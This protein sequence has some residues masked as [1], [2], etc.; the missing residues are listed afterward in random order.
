MSIVYLNDRD[1]ADYGIGLTEANAW[2]A[3]QI[4]FP[5]IS[6][7]GQIGQVVGAV[8]TGQPRT[9]RLTG[10]LRASS[11]ANRRT[12]L[13]Q[14]NGDLGKGLVEIRI[15]DE[16]DRFVLARFV[17]ASF[18]SFSKIEYSGVNSYVTVELEFIC[19]DPTWQDR[20]SQS[21]SFGSTRTGMPLGRMP[22][23][24]LIY[25]EGATNPT[26]HYRSSTGDILYSMTF[27][28]TLA[29]D[30][31]LRI[32]M[33]LQTIDEIDSGVRTNDIASLTSGDF[34]ACDPYDG[35]PDASSW[36]TLEITSGTA[37]AYYRRRWS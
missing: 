24:P 8:G 27:T 4:E 18:G 13:D 16:L 11:I 23:W 37:V 29:A 35:D 19:D 31:V 5:T 21:V 9:L 22:S 20:F 25:V 28:K 26:I 7:L 32:D 15:A 1:I 17:G 33:A 6:V 14:L 3:I 2:D 10:I 30:E 36:P 34:F 12:L